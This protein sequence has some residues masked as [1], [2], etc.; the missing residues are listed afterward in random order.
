MDREVDGLLAPVVRHTFAFGNSKLECVDAVN[1]EEGEGF[2][3]EE[4]NGLEEGAA[5][6]LCGGIGRRRRWQR[7]GDER[8]DPR[9]ADEEILA[10]GFLKNS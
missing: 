3:G 10:V 4:R 2:G 1:G 8:V 7:S 6:D 9:G 5:D